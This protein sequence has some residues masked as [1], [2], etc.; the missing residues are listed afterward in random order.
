M[1]PAQAAA[2]LRLLHRGCASLRIDFGGARA[3][4]FDPCQRPLAD[5]IVVL[6]WNE[7]ERLQGLQAAWGAGEAPELVAGQDLLDGLAASGAATSPPTTRAQVAIDALPYRPVPYATPAEGARKLGSALRNPL[8]AAKRLNRR[9]RLPGAQPRIFQLT[10]PGGARL[11]HLNCALHG[12]TEQAW[13]TR[14]AARFRGADWVIA[15]WDYGEEEAFAERIGLFEPRL[16][17][18]TDLVGQVRGALGLPTGSLTPLADRLSR[19]GTAVQVL[20]PGTSM[21]FPVPTRSQPEVDGV[22]ARSDEVGEE[23]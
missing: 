1:S 14:A 17:I 6:T 12:R 20:A 11:L 8:R 9:A 7:A 18:I 16:L 13:L 4:V 22:R 23:G 2:P 5:E 10:L 19:Q 3:F 21:R 15:A